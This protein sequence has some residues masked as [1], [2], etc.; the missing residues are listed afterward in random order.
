MKEELSSKDIPDISSP[1]T[2]LNTD[3]T[4]IAGTGINSSSRR[5][6]NDLTTA[7]D[8][9]LENKYKSVQSKL[10]SIGDST[11]Q[12]CQTMAN[13]LE[14]IES[15]T[16]SLLSFA[17][18]SSDA[19]RILSDGLNLDESVVPRLYKA[20]SSSTVTGTGTATSLATEFTSSKVADRKS[21]IRV[22]DQRIDEDESLQENESETESEEEGAIEELGNNESTV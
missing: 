16:L 14:S 2:H 19:F 15:S 4:P 5:R 13:R 17:D 22:N 7:A 1:F 3:T 11:S 10:R 8:V 9:A 6:K 18:R 12:A 20:S 21:N